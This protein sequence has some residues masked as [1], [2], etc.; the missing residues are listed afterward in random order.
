MK[1]RFFAV[2][3]VLFLSAALFI[4]AQPGFRGPASER[5]QRGGGFFADRNILPPRLLLQAKE[6]IGL[7]ADQ[8]NKIGAMIE[9]HEQWAIKFGA[10]MKIKALKLRTT[11]AAEK[12][13]LENAEKLIREQADMRAELQIA[14]LRLQMD[15][16][17][18]LTPEQSAK[19]MELKKD[20]PA[21]TRDG[22]RQR[23]ERSRGRRN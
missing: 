19:L 15:A 13:N 6:K 11:L 12:I 2:S 3:I 21:R 5:G 14:R 18:L 8:E 22:M 20:F 16:M 17:A 4:T 1:K 7:N 23:S 9:T 10:E